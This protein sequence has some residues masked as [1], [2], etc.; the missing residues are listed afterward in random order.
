VNPNAPADASAGSSDPAR[1]DPDAPQSDSDAGKERAS[2]E[3]E[4][5]AEWP[6]YGPREATIDDPEWFE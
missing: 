4:A 5:D 1:S 2:E 3:E 6:V